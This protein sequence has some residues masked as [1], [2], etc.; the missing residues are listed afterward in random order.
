MMLG[1][2][3]CVALLDEMEA[4]AFYNHDDSSQLMSGRE[5]VCGCDA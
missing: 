1:K 4:E 5:D 3:S 2:P